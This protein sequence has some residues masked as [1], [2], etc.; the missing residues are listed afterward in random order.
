MTH[1]PQQLFRMFS[2]TKSEPCSQNGMFSERNE[3]NYFKILVP[4][5]LYRR[6]AQTDQM[7]EQ[8][9]ESACA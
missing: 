7:H 4:T 5:S 3:K 9:R 8:V 1:A 6:R 2:A